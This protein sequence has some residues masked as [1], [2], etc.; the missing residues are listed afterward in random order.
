MNN[1]VCVEV[2]PM[3]DLYKVL[4]LLYGQFAVSAAALNAIA[5]RFT[6]EIEDG[7][8]G[9]P[10]SLK[11]LP[12]YL[13]KP[14][15]RERGQY[16]A[17]DFGGTNVRLLLV[18]LAGGGQCR[19]TEHHAWPLKDPAGAYDYT[20]AG[21]S[22]DEL[23]DSI[24]GKLAEFVPGNRIYPLGHTFSFPCRQSGVNQ[25]VLIHWTKEIKTRGVEGR[26]IGMLLTRAL[27]RA[28]R[29]NI[30]PQAIIND[31]VGT[32]LAAAYS[33][34]SVMAGSICGTGH[35]TCYLEPDAPLT[36][37]PMIL[38]MESGNFDTHTLN[39][40][41]QLLDTA[42]ERPGEQKLEKQV[43]GRYLGELFRLV[44]ADLCT[45][46]LIAAEGGHSF[47]EPYSIKSEHLNYLLNETGAAANGDSFQDYLQTGIT[48]DER[49]FFRSI[50][51][52]ITARSA[53][54]VAATYL[55]TL[56]HTDPE[57]TGEHTIAID[58]SLYEK[59]PGYRETIEKTLKQHLPRSAAVKTR[60]TKDGSGVGAA[61]AAAVSALS[62]L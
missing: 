14:S 22:G 39:Y 45:K 27:E 32:L 50:A 5:D 54:L 53:K 34:S 28:G 51:A 23:F 9:A 7:L 43:A 48:I 16:L 56:R 6:Q 35:N 21:V 18:E 15:G 60:L 13:A 30:I 19:V 24:A 36:G 31:T 11:L 46:D 61:V 1:D 59:M 44:I 49:R 41:D 47:S 52:L 40:Y 42:S 57:L 10:V 26:D 20:S 58:G 33:D 37:K 2:I 17:L 25:A 38:N 4:A 62:A 55:G 12:S 8:S 29:A 3:T